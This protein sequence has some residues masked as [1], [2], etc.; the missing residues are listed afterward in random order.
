[1]DIINSFDIKKVRKEVQSQTSRKK[2]IDN[3]MCKLEHKSTLPRDI[4]PKTNRYAC[5]YKHANNNIILPQ[6]AE[7]GLHP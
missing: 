7:M 1:M 3:H 2:N 5:G 4:T 6:H